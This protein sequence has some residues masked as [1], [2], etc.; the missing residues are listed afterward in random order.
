[1]PNFDGTGPREFGQ[2]GRGRGFGAGS[3]GGRGMGLCSSRGA[4]ATFLEREEKDLSLRL[5]RVRQAKNA[6]EK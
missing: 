4:D 5:E 2:G 1:M 3:R 6:V